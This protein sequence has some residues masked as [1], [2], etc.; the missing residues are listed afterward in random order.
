MRGMKWWDRIG[1]MEGIG[2]LT[3]EQIGGIRKGSDGWIYRDR[4]I[5]GTDRRDE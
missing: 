3:D 1:R 4:R 5:G 2:G